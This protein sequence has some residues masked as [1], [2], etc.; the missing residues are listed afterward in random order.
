MSTKRIAPQEGPQEK[1]LASPAD[2]AIYGGGA[3]GGKTFALLLEP[4]RYLTT[5]RNFGGVIFR[6]TSPQI[7]NEGGLWDESVNLYSFVGGR[8]RES[9]LDWKFP[10]YGNAI[11][12]MHME[13]ESNKYDHQGAQYAY[14]GFDELTHFSKGQ[15]FYLLSRNRSMSGV[16]GYIRGT[17]NPD[18]DSWVAEFISWWID[19]DTGFAIPERSG[20]LRY[21]YRVSDS[22]IWGDTPEELKEKYP[23][24][25]VKVDIRSVTFIAASVY[26]NKMLMER[27]P[28]YLASLKALPLVERERLLGGNWK[29]KAASGTVFKREWFEIVD[30]P[31]PLTTRVRYWDRA[32]TKPNKKNKQPDWTVGLKMLRD[33]EGT[34]YVEHISRFRESTEKVIKSICNLAK[35][36]GHNTMVGFWQ[37]PAQAGKFEMKYYTRRLA[38]YNVRAVPQTNNKLAYALP[39]SAQCEAGNV[40]IVKGLWNDDFL[41]ELENFSG[42]NLDVDDQVDAASGAF[43]IL[44]E[45]MVLTGDDFNVTGSMES[46]REFNGM[47]YAEDAEGVIISDTYSEFGS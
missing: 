42:S 15:F 31:P 12:F 19:Q 40:K 21:M 43:K 18:P 24:I 34:F 22:I 16:S 13:H 29:I 30:F 10:P 26:D 3:G 11:S 38:G 41:T 23:E 4:L 14:I 9:K 7:T 44:A 17:C 39:F 1:F 27:D 6:R 20:V 45:K 37:D 47:D 32:G 5:V 28:T 25:D 2:I 46:H 8:S 33:R 35:Q 36:D